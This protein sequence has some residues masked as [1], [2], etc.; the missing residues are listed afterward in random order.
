M[1]QTWPF[2]DR[3]LDMELVD[4]VARVEDDDG[5]FLSL[6]RRGLGKFGVGACLN[7]YSGEGYAENVHGRNEKLYLWENLFSVLWL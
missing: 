5:F 2:P 6:R 3:R 7:L 4:L 1:S